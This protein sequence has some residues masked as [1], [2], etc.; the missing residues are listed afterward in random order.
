LEGTNDF[1]QTWQMD[2][3]L[4]LSGIVT[5]IPLYFFGLAARIVP[6][7]IMGF[8]QYFSPSIQ[9]LLGIFLFGES[10]S[11]EK[12]ISFLLIWVAL[13]VFTF[14]SIIHIRKAKRDAA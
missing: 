9:L 10:F 3:S 12:Q 1:G 5:V 2:L 11:R 6:L 4:A 7:S 13:G 14:D 8:M